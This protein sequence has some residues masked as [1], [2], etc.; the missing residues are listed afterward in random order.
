V[1]SPQSPQ[2]KR[3]SP[4]V[5]F[6]GVQVVA[7]ALL[8]VPVYRAVTSSEEQRVREQVRP[9]SPVDDYGDTTVDDSREVTV[10]ITTEVHDE[11]PWDFEVETSTVTVHP[12]E[13]KVVMFHARNR[14]DE[15][16]DGKAI[17]DVTPPG[18][19]AHFKKV[20]C[21]CFT[22]QT[23]GPGEEAEM[24]VQ[25][26][27]DPAIGSDIDDVTVNYRFFNMKSSVRGTAQR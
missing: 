24:P 8:A 5:I 26:W 20:E 18:A 1:N 22:Q 15:P 19:A 13:R 23:L 10:R 11:L 16:I 2:K 3:V 6:A 4:I 7:L 17:Y 12:G 9:E 27:L 25:F 14:A 21:F